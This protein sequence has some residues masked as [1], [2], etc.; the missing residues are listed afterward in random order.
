M[1]I[2][3]DT[4]YKNV[5]LATVGLLY[6]LLVYKIKISLKNVGYSKFSVKKRDHDGRMN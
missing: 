3:T 1:T 6:F 5:L 4:S 2:I